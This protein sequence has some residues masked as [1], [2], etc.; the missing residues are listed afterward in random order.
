MVGWGG[1]SPNSG[2][3]APLPSSS[4]VVSFVLMR[5]EKGSH[6]GISWTPQVPHA[7]LLSS[8][9]PHGIGTS[10]SIGGP[11]CPH[12]T[13]PG[14]ETGISALWLCR[15]GNRFMRCTRGGTWPPPGSLLPRAACSPAL[16]YKPL[17]W[18]FGP[19]G[20]QRGSARDR[21][22]CLRRPRWCPR[23]LLRVSVTRAA[24]QVRPWWLR[25]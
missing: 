13:E 7:H 24:W 6:V 3:E 12:H 22:S 15:G 25:W 19:Q 4:E 1:C 20:Q 14:K 18:C 2:W 10:C 11:H 21:A 9:T 8:P 5:Y 16:D 17:G 23:V